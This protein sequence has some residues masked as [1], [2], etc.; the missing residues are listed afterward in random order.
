LAQVPFSSVRSVT[1]VIARHSLVAVVRRLAM[2]PD[3]VQP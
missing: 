2:P 3:S 1:P